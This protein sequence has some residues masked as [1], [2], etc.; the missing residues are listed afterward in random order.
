M[1]KTTS[2]ISTRTTFGGVEPAPLAHT[3]VYLFALLTALPLLVLL[4]SFFDTDAHIWAHLRRYVLPQIS[5]NTLLLTVGVATLTA[6]LGVGLA[7][8]TAMFRFPGVRFFAWGLMLPLA[9]P[10]YVLAFVQ[11]GLFDFG[12]ALR[13]LAYTLGLADWLPNVRS[14]PGTII[15]MT[16]AFYPYVYLLARNAFLTQ[17]QRALEVGA[18]LGLSPRQAFIRV[19]LPLARP[20]IVAG[21]LLVVMETLADFGVVAITGVDTFTTAI[22]KSWFAFFSLATASQLACLLMLLALA[23]LALEQRARKARRYLPTGRQALVR[24]Q[25]LKGWRAS[26]S[27][28][29][30]SVVLLM[31]FVVPVLQL[32]V[33]AW[34]ESQGEFDWRY[35]GFA[36]N[37]LSVS[38]MAAAIVLIVAWQIG[39]VQRQQVSPAMNW[40]IRISTLGYAIP[41]AVLAVAIFLPMAWLDT[42]AA[43]W[44]DG[45]RWFSGSL[46]ALLVAYAIRFM[47]VGAGP[48]QAGWQRISAHHDMVSHSLGVSGFALFRRVHWPLLRMPAL[49]ASLLVFV[50]VMKELPITLMMRPFGWDTLAI[51][52]F[53]WTSEGQWQQAALPSLLLV[54]VGLLPVYLLA[55]QRD[56]KM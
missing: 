11:T 33:W 15:V 22:Y 40:A 55:R 47:A 44:F 26:A 18:S 6:V 19:A 53:E 37:S 30:C 10:A 14:L 36:W 54:L 34:Q 42:Q 7:W 43:A 25:A 56:D 16:G 51:R 1:F 2:V 27:T 29:I 32:S 5:L 46:V 9:M 23:L 3:S 17:G 20:W 13:E 38:L 35:F 39:R 52:I 8:L 31:V 4:S 21:V 48:M 28:A 49:T 41:G 12:G 24:T 45:S 50:D